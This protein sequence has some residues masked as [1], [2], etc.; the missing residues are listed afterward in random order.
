MSTDSDLHRETNLKCKNWYITKVH[1]RFSTILRVKE[2]IFQKLK[3]SL[4][5]SSPEKLRNFCS[6]MSHTATMILIQI[7]LMSQTAMILIQI[8]H[9]YNHIS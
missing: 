1:H 4:V 5:K 8:Q 3:A 7:M 2:G 9:F 6:T